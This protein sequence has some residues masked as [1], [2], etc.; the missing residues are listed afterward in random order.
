MFEKFEI[1]FCTLASKCAYLPDRRQKMDYI[2]IQDCTFEYNSNLVKHGY[3]RFGEFFSKPICDNCKEC[4]SVRI[5]AFGFKFSKS[6]RRV[7]SKNQ[8]TKILISTPILDQEHLDLY[9]K[10]HLFMREKKGWEFHELNYKKYH[11]L[12]VAGACDF[13]FE[14]GYYYDNRLICVDLIDFVDDGIS[15][16]YC[17]YDPDFSH[18][19]LGKFSLLN[20][21]LIAKEMKKRWIYLGFYVKNCPSLSY[22]GEYK[23]YQILQD[24]V[25]LQEESIW[26]FENME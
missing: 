25:D 11:E 17:Y 1:P 7:M 20:Q 26:S 15:S 23:P 6:L 5:D 12:Y 2:F 4:K 13:G 14:I 24:Y 9:H 8:D 21:I 3:R 22:K 16:I 10:Y 19:S 18:L